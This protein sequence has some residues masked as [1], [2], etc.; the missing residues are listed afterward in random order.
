[1]ESDLKLI[2]KYSKEDGDDF[3]PIIERYLK[4]IYNFI[5]Q[6]VR[7]KSVADDLTQITFIKAWKNIH[8][9]DHKRKFRTWLYSITK[10]TALDHLKKKKSLPFSFFDDPDGNNPLSDIRD[11]S[12]L[13]DEMLERED[14]SRNIDQI[15]N[16]LPD[17][18]R[19]ILMMRYRDDIDLREISHVLDISYNTVK[20]RHQRALLR[21]RKILDEELRPIL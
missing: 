4:S 8:R 7:D 13:P 14:L 10:N 16:K 11:E 5:Y 12:I 3:S 20:S 15:L 19:I 21:L 17:I 1:M 2:E 6:F 18:Y 9:F